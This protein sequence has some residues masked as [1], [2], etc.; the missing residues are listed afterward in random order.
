MLHRSCIFQELDDAEST[1]FFTETLPEIIRLALRLPDLIP[2]AIPLL[3]HGTSK[4]ISLSQEQVASLLANA[5]L[6]TFPRRN[7]HNRKSEY[8]NFPSINF[9]SLYQTRN[10][11]D[12]VIEKI[13][14]IC[15]YFRT[16]CKKSKCSASPPRLKHYDNRVL[17]LQCQSER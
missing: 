4:S 16:I 2:S 13:K 1:A 9:N 15:Y 6:C 17:Y 8:R 12:Q 5:F 3:K 11:G 14:C 10:G 7:E